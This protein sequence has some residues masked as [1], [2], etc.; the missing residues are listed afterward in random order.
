[1]FVLFKLWGKVIL[2]W[3]QKDKNVEKWHKSGTIKMCAVVSLLVSKSQ[4]RASAPSLFLSKGISEKAV[5]WNLC[6]IFFG[7]E[8]ENFTCQYMN[9]Q[10]RGFPQALINL[11]Y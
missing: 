5:V 4:L 3:A 2:K 7:C 1:M 11:I 8:I 10:Q 9:I 6:W